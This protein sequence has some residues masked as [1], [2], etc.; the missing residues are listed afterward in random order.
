MRM[1][2]RAKNRAK[3]RDGNLGGD[4]GKGGY[5]GWERVINR[6]MLSLLTAVA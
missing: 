2:S 1:R 4:T 3:S 6:R 5:L